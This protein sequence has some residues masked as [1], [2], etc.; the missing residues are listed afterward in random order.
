MPNDLRIAIHF[1][2]EKAA[3][4]HLV[5]TPGELQALEY[6]L[7]NFNSE[8]LHPLNLRLE[9]EALFR[10][11]LEGKN[12][13]GSYRV[14]V[15]NRSREEPIESG[16]LPDCL[17]QCAEYEI[18]LRARK[19]AQSELEQKLKETTNSLMGVQERAKSDLERKDKE[20]EKSKKDAESEQKNSAEH[21]RKTMELDKK[22][23][24][25][26]R[27]IEGYEKDIK[28]LRERLAKYETISSID[29]PV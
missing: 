7:E 18:E 14:N 20:I 3:S 23:K 8:I 24:D 16:K 6:R 29:D 1:R 11:H 22:W 10:K 12:W 4:A 17:K 15:Q 2:T 9:N 25:A 19:N 27:K 5:I 26:Q 28:D 13:N 21:R